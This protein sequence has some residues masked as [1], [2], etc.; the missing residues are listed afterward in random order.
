MNTDTHHLGISVVTFTPKLIKRPAAVVRKVGRGAMAAVSYYEPIIVQRLRVGEYNVVLVRNSRNVR[1]V[2]V[3][4]VGIVNES[5]FDKQ[6]A[7]IRGGA[8]PPVPTVRPFPA[9]LTN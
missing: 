2:I 9:C 4:C 8:I 5:V 6:L 1:K 3:V 7:G